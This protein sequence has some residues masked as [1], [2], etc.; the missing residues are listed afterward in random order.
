VKRLD[1]L[2]AFLARGANPTARDHPQRTPLITQVQNEQVDL[3]ARLLQDPRVRAILHAQSD[4]HWTAPHYA[5]DIY[6]EGIATAMVRLLLRAG[7]EPDSPD[8]KGATP[9]SYLNAYHPEHH[10]P[11][12]H[13]TLALLKQAKGGKADDEIEG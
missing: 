7:A 3:V 9:L 13:S 12:H 6:E 5:V 2:N 11:E 10:H 4:A 1:L 8:D